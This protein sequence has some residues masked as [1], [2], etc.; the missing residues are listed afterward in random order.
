M[1]T[2]GKMIPMSERLETVS[3]HHQ[4]IGYKTSSDKARYHMLNTADSMRRP[5]LLIPFSAM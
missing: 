4:A 2:R 1:V 5:I 3:S